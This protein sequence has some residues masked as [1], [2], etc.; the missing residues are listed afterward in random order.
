VDGRPV[1]QAILHWQGDIGYLESA[2]TLSAYRGRGLQQALI[3]RRI[4]DAMAQGCRL[5]IGGAEF[6]SP[7]V[8]NQMACGLAVAYTAARWVQRPEAMLVVAPPE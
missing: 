6:A 7:S 5:I 8:A 2:G 4:A 3:R 1:A